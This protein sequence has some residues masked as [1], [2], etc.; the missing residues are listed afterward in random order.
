MARNFDN[1]GDNLD[2]VRTDGGD[3]RTAVSGGI[4][5]GAQFSA[6]DGVGAS[7]KR[8]MVLLHGGAG[9]RI[10]AVGDR[11][12]N[13]GA[14]SAAAEAGSADGISGDMGGGGVRSVSEFRD[15]ISDVHISVH[16]AGVD[17]D[18]A[19]FV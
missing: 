1:A 13:D 2:V 8:R 19:D 17:N 12:D 7:G 6:G 14:E 18:S 9:G 10:T 11:A 3:T 15:E 4:S 5:W 16:D